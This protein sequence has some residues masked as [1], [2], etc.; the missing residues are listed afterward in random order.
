MIPQ[1][2][3]MFIWQLPECEGGDYHK[4]V[5]SALGAKLSWVAIKVVNGTIPYAPQGMASTYPL[6]LASTIQALKAAGIKVWGWG[7]MYGANPLGISWAKAEADITISQTLGYQLEG[8]FIDPESEYKRSGAKVWAAV[9]MAAIRSAMP[10]TPLGLCSY[11]FPRYHPE[12]PWAE[13]LRN[14]DF[15]VPQMY[16]EGAH[17]PGY[18]LETSVG[19]LRAL[20]DIPIIPIGSAYPKGLWSPTYGDLM[21]FDNKAKEL[22]LPGDGWWSWQHIED[23]VEWWNLISAMQWNIVQPPT[24]PVLTLEERVSKLE[25]A[26]RSKGWNI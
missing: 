14:C 4:I 22:G 26:A 15:H 17:N 25:S 21:E 10:T 2:K 24:P 9:Y 23:N 7:Y 20:K 6:M 8:Y 16:W 5:N 12:L 19:Q 13:F 3:G 18:Q 1:G 11:R